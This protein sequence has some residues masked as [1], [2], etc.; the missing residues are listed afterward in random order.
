MRDAQQLLCVLTVLG[1]LSVRQVVLQVAV[2]LTPVSH[3]PIQLVCS[4]MQD[5]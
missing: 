2:Q 4:V 5:L 3:L 1:R